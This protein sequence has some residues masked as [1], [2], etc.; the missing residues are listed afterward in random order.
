MKKIDTSLGLAN[1]QFS[2][3]SSS[4]TIWNSYSKI[5]LRHSPSILGAIYDSQSRLDITNALKEKSVSGDIFHRSMFIQAYSIF[6]F[7]IK[8]VTTEIID[9]ISFGKEKYSCFDQ[10][11]RDT[12]LV[13]T[14]KVLSHLK[15]GSVNGIP[16]NFATTTKNLGDCLLN[17]EPFELNKEVFTLLMGNCTPERIDALFKNLN[18]PCPFDEK[19]SSLGRH[20]GLQKH[21]AS[22][23]TAENTRQTTQKLKEMIDKRN[24]MVHG[25]ITSTITLN[26]LEETVEF[27]KFLVEALNDHI[28]QNIK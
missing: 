8:A 6:E 21:F 4:I 17:L 10:K 13:L 5:L 14:A 1:L 9:T 20:N 7:Y 16:H 18:L 28:C 11:F 12:H 3:I 15:S 23:K 27:T 26:E 22:G 2:E 25:N 24:D 19:S